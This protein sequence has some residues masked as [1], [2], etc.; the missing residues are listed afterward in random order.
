LVDGGGLAGFPA[1]N[2]DRIESTLSE[3][4][5]SLVRGAAGDA[6]AGRSFESALRF[7][8]GELEVEITREPHLVRSAL[9]EANVQAFF[10]E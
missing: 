5:L 3:H 8:E 4:R 7:A 9:V 6:I 1:A 2:L 10:A